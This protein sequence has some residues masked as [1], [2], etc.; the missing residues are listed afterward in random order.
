MSGTI[1]VSEAKPD[2]LDTV[3]RLFDA[4][5]MFYRQPTDLAAARTFLS[6]RFRRRDSVIFIAYRDGE[7][8]GFTQLYPSLSSVS[9]AP[10]WILND[11]FVN[12]TAR[13]HGVGRQLM[14]RAREFA[15]A[16]GAVRLELTTER[17]NTTAQALYRAAG[18]ARDDVFYKF[19][20]TVDTKA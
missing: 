3:A 11:L 19:I 14:D 5:R 6:E 18:Y 17:N 13:A 2:D 15:R 20:L 16:S 10:I 1:T 4:Y 9:M 7:P 12:A 8:A